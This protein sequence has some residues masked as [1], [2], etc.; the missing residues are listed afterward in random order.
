M[1]LTDRF[2]WVVTLLFLSFFLFFWGLGRIPFYTKGEPREALE[3]WEEVHEGEW[4]LPMRN[5]RELPSKPPLFH[6]LGGVTASLTGD[7]DELS[8]RL[9]SAILSSLTLL[10]VFWAGARRFGARAGG[11]AAIILATSFEWMR[12][13]TTARVDMTLTAFLVG[14]FLALH[15]VVSQERPRFAAL[16]ALYLCMALATLAKGPVGIILPGLCALVYLAIRGDLARL[17][18]MHVVLGG[19]V[20]LAVAGSWYA[21]AIRA[22][23]EGFVHKQLLVENALRFFAA[24]SSGAGHVHP[25]Y[26]MIGGVLTGF[27]PWSFFLFPLGV[28][29]YQNRRRLEARGLLYFIVWFGVVFIFYSVSQ[30]K[31]TVYLLPAYPAAALLLGSWWQELDDNEALMPKSVLGV[32]RAVAVI[33]VVVVVLVVATLLAQ[34]VGAEP[35]ERI[36]PYLHPKDQQNIPALEDIV[37][38]RAVVLI[39]WLA[40]LLMV[41]FVFASSVARR[42]WMIVFAS[43][44][45]FVTSTMAVVNGV[46]HPQLAWRRTF[47]PFMEIVRGVVADDDDLVFYKAFD[48]GAVFYSRRHIRTFRGDLAQ[49][50]GG[51]GRAYVL[52]WESE[53]NRLSPSDRA[54]LEPLRTSEGTGPKGRD[55]LLFALVKPTP[56][57][58]GSPGGGDASRPARQNG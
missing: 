10:A 6:W 56:N 24:R 11:I 26:Y 8:V 18:R 7:V 25:F 54:R 34:A 15:A 43:L 19:I 58:A 20:T 51:P 2:P 49:L 41:V 16:A 47:K 29:L 35:L 48:Y 33:M 53:W 32:L 57:G 31:R 37:G 42:R 45:A 50:G 39:P 13:A 4:L 17:R 38:S 52:L 5:G 55:R 40:V 27:A 46:F 14:A 22:G 1:H 21:L 28:F 12:A 9:P 23:G 3:V 36:R 30:S 44:V